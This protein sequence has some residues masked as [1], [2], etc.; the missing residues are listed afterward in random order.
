MDR[1]QHLQKTPRLLTSTP[2]TTRKTAADRHAT[3]E[4]NIEP[5]FLRTTPLIRPELRTVE[6][7]PSSTPGNERDKLALSTRINT[8]RSWGRGPVSSSHDHCAPNIPSPPQLQTTQRQVCRH[9]SQIKINRG[10]GVAGSAETGYRA[11][12]QGSTSNIS[13]G[14]NATIDT[15]R[16]LGEGGILRPHPS[17]I[18]SQRFVAFLVISLRRRERGLV[19]STYSRVSPA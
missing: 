1:F 5:G 4:C 10:L 19:G 13:R 8:N 6:S 15:S 14:A 7:S 18:S 11:W 2:G 16:S 17:Q 12:I 3:H 9:P